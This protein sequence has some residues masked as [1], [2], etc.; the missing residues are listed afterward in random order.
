MF[1]AKEIRCSLQEGSWVHWPPEGVTVWKYFICWTESEAPVALWWAVNT[2]VHYSV[3]K[4][5]HLFCSMFW[6]Q[7]LPTSVLLFDDRTSRQSELPCFCGHSEGCPNVFNPS[8]YTE[9]PLIWFVLVSI[10]NQWLMRDSSPFR[11]PRPCR[12]YDLAM[13]FRVQFCQLCVMCKTSH[14]EVNVYIPFKSSWV[15]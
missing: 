6:R 4:F 12:Q 2:L 13:M 3:C 11:S 1:S 14:H 8:A 7:E 5:E 9:N 15:N 10:S